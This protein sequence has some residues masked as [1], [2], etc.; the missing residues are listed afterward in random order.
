M[1]EVIGSAL[2]LVLSMIGKWIWLQIFL[3][4]CKKKGSLLSSILFPGGG[5]RDLAFPSVLLLKCFIQA[6]SLYFRSKTFGCPLSPLRF[7]CL[8]GKRPGVKS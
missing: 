1:V 8:L 5:R 7:P 2:L 4:S 3:M 6:L